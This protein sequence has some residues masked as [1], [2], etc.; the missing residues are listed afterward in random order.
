MDSIERQISLC[1]LRAS[2]LDE[3]LGAYSYDLQLGLVRTALRLARSMEAPHAITI[4]VL[5]TIEAELAERIN[6]A[7]SLTNLIFSGE[8]D[9]SD[10]LD[11]LFRSSAVTEYARET[12]NIA[13]AHDGSGV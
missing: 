5:T 11:D 9:T 10:S 13:Y 3:I 4:H 7:Q 6:H 1:V 12:L 8:Y 2:L